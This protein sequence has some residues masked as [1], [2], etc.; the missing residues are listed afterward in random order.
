MAFEYLNE[1]DISKL[2][3]QSIIKGII[4][5]VFMIKEDFYMKTDINFILLIADRIELFEYYF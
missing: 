1:N 4:E 5:Y 2:F 3:L